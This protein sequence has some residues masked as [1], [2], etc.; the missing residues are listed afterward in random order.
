[1]NSNLAELD[2][3]SPATPPVAPPVLQTAR[4][5]PAILVRVDRCAIASAICG[6]TAFVPVIS[7]VAGIVL[8]VIALRRIRRVR[9]L[10][11]PVTGVGWAV[12]GLVSSIFVLLSWIF[13]FAVMAAVMYMFRE[14]AAVLDQV[15]PPPA[16]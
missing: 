1:M 8:G 3:A 7:Q 6:L 12:T 15:T 16:P 13:V 5:T 14:T 4:D 9:R 10:G 11:H 2:K